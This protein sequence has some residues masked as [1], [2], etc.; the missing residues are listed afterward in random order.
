M[1]NPLWIS[2]P[3]LLAAHGVLAAGSNLELLT[4]AEPPCVFGGHAIAIAVRFHNPSDQE[5]DHDI[6][7]GLY[8]ASSA[9]AIPLGAIPWKELRVLPRQTVLESASVD[10]PP[11]KAR[12]RFLVQ[13]L[14]NSNHVIGTTTVLVYPTN[15]LDEL[16]RLVPD[17][18]ENLG[19]LDPGRQLTPALK[20]AAVKF[21]D[22]EQA[23]LTGFSGRLALIGPC[24]PGDPEWSGLAGRVR[25][26]A[27]Q[28]APVVWIQSPPPGLEKPLPSFY[29]VPVNTNAVVVVQ[30]ELVAG[31]ADHPQSQLNLLYFCRL[32]LHPQPPAWPDLS[33]Q[34]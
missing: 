13:W 6:Q 18:G 23:D 14:E 9:T 19:V 20:N 33:P 5:Y 7:I 1:K 4:N 10:F 11:V 27:R 34:P 24:R 30:P 25:Q 16:K 2:I 31:L 21:V 3:L 15:L 12:T 29:V 32:A 22:L 8:Q 28:G 17:G 26:L